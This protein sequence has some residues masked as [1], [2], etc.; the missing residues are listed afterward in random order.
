VS[1]AVG[2]AGRHSTRLLRSSAV[3]GLGT[4]LSR[5][6]GFLR[7]AAIAYAIGAGALAGTYSYASQTPNMLYEL[8]LGG[9][10]TATLVPQFVRHVERD[11]E[12]AVNAI[13]TVAIA[14]LVVL[15][16]AGVLLAPYI[17][18]LFTLRVQGSARAAQQDV[19]TS[20]VRLFM[21]QMLFFG[22]TALAT[23][24]LNAHR[25]FAAAAFAPILNNLVVIAIFLSLPRLVDGPITLAR[26]R[27]DTPLL[28]TL[29]LGTTAGIAVV[30]IALFPAL[31]WAGVRLRFVWAWRHRAV[32]T[33]ARLSGWTVG[34]VI[35]NQVA[36]WIVLI[37]ANG[38]EGG[39]FVYLSAYAFFQLPHGLLAV[40]L[41]TTIAPEMASAADRNDLAGLRERLS[42]G[43]RTTTFVIVPFAAIFISLARPIVVAVL[44]RGAFSA[45]DA[46]VVAQTIAGFSVGLVPFSIYLFSLRAF[47]SLQD[48]RTPFALNCF[49]NALN[50]ALAFPL[51]YAFGVPGLALAFAGAY[52]GAAALTLWSLRHRIGYLDTRRFGNTLA[53]SLAAG[54][55]VALAAWLVARGVGWSSTWAALGATAVGTVIGFAEYIAVAAALRMRELDDLWS[56]FAPQRRRGGPPA[57]PAPARAATLRGPADSEGR[58]V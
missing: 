10:L 41:M 20:L 47:Y 1:D 34:Y 38:R 58:T 21:P 18:K 2:A 23:A 7:V 29:G 6:T 42:F 22:F 12:E 55:L 40:S 32:L 54:G 52:A 39:P 26:V 43:L 35:A 14:A 31:R 53:R 37:L 17:V 49:E 50:I 45:A 48:T 30:A 24:L 33:M 19:A 5:V 36:L 9:V 13:M 28:L 15:S 56:L 3:V 51:Y 4:A 11:D 46:E 27:D 8:L 44:Q 16:V 25:R 57:A